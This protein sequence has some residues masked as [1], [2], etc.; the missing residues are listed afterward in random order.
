[1]TY[2]C[3]GSTV[4]VSVHLELGSDGLL[5]DVSMVQH[6]RPEL[7]ASRHHVISRPAIWQ[8]PNWTHLLAILPLNLE[9]VLKQDQVDFSVLELHLPLEQ[10]SERPHDGT[11]G[12]D[13]LVREQAERAKLGKDNGEVLLLDRLEG[14][15]LLDNST[16]VCQR[17]D[18]V[19]GR[20][21]GTSSDQ[22]ELGDE[23]STHAS[24]AS[25]PAILAVNSNQVDVL[26]SFPRYSL[27]ESSMNPSSTQAMTTSGK[28]PYRRVPRVR[29]STSLRP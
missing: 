8:N 10:L 7:W 11:T 15:K 28:P 1:M 14:G 19:S 17:G 23:V 2:H 18:R 9:N 24:V 4:P 22:S 6:L 3:G 21:R 27:S 20:T 29:L 5:C 25:T 13:L 16:G 26:A 12:H